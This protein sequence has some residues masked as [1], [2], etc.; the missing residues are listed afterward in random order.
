M[1]IFMFY[2]LNI[3]VFNLK[4][5]ALVLKFHFFGGKQFNFQKSH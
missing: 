3:Q 4:K 1:H 2:I 5:I